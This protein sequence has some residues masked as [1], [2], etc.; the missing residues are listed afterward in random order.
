MKYRKIIL[1]VFIVLVGASIIYAL[2]DQ[3]KVTTSSEKAYQ[4][5]L[6]GEDYYYRLYRTEALQEFEKAAKLDPNFAMAFARVAWLYRDEDNQ[7]KYQEAKTRALSLLDRVKEKERIV[8]NLGFARAEGRTADIDR[9]ITELLD[10]YPDCFEA[11]DFLS[12]KYLTER[13]FDKVI[14]ENLAILKNAPNHAP[15]YNLLAYSYFY[16]GDHKKALE[17]ID[18]YTSLAPDQANPHDSHG[19]LL[20]NMGN[21]DEALAQFRMADSIK[22]NLYFVVSH[23]GNTYEAKGMY[24]DAIGAYLKTRDL[25]P[26]ARMR[27]NLDANIAMCYMEN[28]QPEKGISILQEAIAKVPDDIRCNGLLGAIYAEQGRMEDALVQLGIVKGIV[29]KSISPQDTSTASS[30]SIKVAEFFLEGRIALAKGDYQGAVEGFEKLYGSSM[31]PDRILYS[32]L[33]G[34]A[35]IRAGMPDSA[36]TILTTALKDNPNHNMCLRTLADAYGKK[37]QR[38]A[39]TDI[40]T[41][42]LAVM[43]DADEGNPYVS[44][45]STDLERLNRKNL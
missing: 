35:L 40:L 20:L 8:I 27:A 42:Y 14:D 1:I 32:A 24:R 5:Y 13:N 9:Y 25:V 10:K 26:S 41:R 17:Y 29:A 38:D 18:K 16:K 19:E 3:R 39:Q 33:L 36:I 4:A 15:S 21:Y 30:A 12:T 28:G 2:M 44:Q 11:H 45:A 6:K 43:K 31:L 23:I 37:G 7:E 34:Q 22:P